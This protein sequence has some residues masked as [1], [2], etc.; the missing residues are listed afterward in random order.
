MIKRNIIKKIFLS[1]TALSGALV[2]GP[3]SNAQ[4]LNYS[5]TTEEIN[6]LSS[7]WDTYNN[8]LDITG[9]VNIYSLTDDEDFD[10]YSVL[11]NNDGTLKNNY[12][13][14]NINVDSSLNGSNKDISIYCE[15]K[16]FYFVI[17]NNSDSS[18]IFNKCYIDSG[19]FNF[20]VDNKGEINFLCNEN[21]YND[22]VRCSP[23]CV[24]AYKVSFN[25]TLLYFAKNYGFPF[26]DGVN[27][28]FQYTDYFRLFLNKTN[29]NN[30]DIKIYAYN[31][32]TLDVL[33]DNYLSY[34]TASS[35]SYQEGYDR[36]SSI[37]YS[38]GHDEGYDEGFDVGYGQ[39][40]SVGYNEGQA[41]VSQTNSTIMGLFGAIANVPITIL[42]SVMGPT[43]LGIPLITILL[44]FLSV[45]L[46][47]WLIKKLIR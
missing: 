18:F 8:E 14:L 46:I 30:Q 40:R 12:Q 36:G 24:S 25:S 41:S 5:F 7:L 38:N 4:N 33:L 11:F 10:K 1:L 37:G 42:N 26:Y 15:M 47:L 27:N 21:E 20:N 3:I 29:Y 45:L 39:G 28:Y 32:D 19:G 9:N 43:L 34:Q 17:C 6:N 31:I 22:Y 35:D 2:L 44:N 23:R 16:D 13:G